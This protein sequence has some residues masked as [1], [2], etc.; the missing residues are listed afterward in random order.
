LRS[1]T[2][3]AQ[4]MLRHYQWKKF[5]YDCVQGIRHN[6]NRGRT[7]VAAAKGSFEKMRSIF[8]VPSRAGAESA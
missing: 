7:A 5:L 3:G 8:A 1:S 6:R 4:V 2:A